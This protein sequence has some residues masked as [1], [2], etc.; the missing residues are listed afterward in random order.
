MDKKL[1]N[2]CNTE[3]EV[4]HHE[5]KNEFDYPEY[6]SFCPYCYDSDGW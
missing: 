3:L 1:C 6:T 4:T 5:L 2:K